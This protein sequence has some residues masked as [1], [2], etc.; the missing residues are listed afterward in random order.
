[1][2]GTNRLRRLWMASLSALATGSGG[3]A[4]SLFR[5]S[6]LANQDDDIYCD[7]MIG[8]SWFFDCCHDD[9]WR[10]N[11]S[12]VIELLEEVDEHE[13]RRSWVLLVFIVGKYIRWYILRMP[14][15]WFALNVSWFQEFCFMRKTMHWMRKKPIRLMASSTTRAINVSSQF[16][17][18]LFFRI[19][20]LFIGWDRVLETSC[21]VGRAEDVSDFPIR[22]NDTRS[23]SLGTKPICTKSEYSPYESINS[24]NEQI[25]QHFTIILKKNKLYIQ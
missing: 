22:P 14:N 17:F 8:L 2:C 7:S 10:G 11:V 23:M 12:S 20:L 18:K 19:D 5:S 24:T 25:E 6:L 1:M 13:P 3:R 9:D 4:T 15:E 16:S 21:V